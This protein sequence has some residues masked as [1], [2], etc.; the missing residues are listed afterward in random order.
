MG[1]EQYSIAVIH[2]IEDPLWSLPNASKQ[3]KITQICTFETPE[4]AHN[5]P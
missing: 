5:P 4:R 2:S 3:Y 1:T